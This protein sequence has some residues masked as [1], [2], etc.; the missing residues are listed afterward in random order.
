VLDSLEPTD[1]KPTKLTRWAREIFTAARQLNIPDEET[2]QMVIVY[3]KENYYSDSQVR[4]AL[5]SNG[6]RGYIPAACRD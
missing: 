6:H 4:Y 2:A 3:A 5:K 1:L